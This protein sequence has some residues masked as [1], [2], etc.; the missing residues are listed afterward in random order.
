MNKHQRAALRR[1]A[2]MGFESMRFGRTFRNRTEV[3]SVNAGYE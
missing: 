2:L 1:P 3:L